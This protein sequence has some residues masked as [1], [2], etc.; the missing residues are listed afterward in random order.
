MR[1]SNLFDA[2]Q[3]NLFLIGFAFYALFCGVVLFL[4]FPFVARLND[5][6]DLLFWNVQSDTADAFFKIIAFL[7]STKVIGIFVLLAAAHAYFSA[8][9]TE[10]FS[11][12]VSLVAA[13][14]VGEILK[15]FFQIERPLGPLV[16]T[17]GF[18]FPSGHAILT[19]VLFFS[20][21]N[22]IGRI[23]RRGTRIFLN[24]AIF[25][26]CLA[27]LISRMYLHAHWFTDIAG[28]FFLGTSI[29]LL[30]NCASQVFKLKS[31]RTW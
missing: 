23:P 18:S 9:K 1:K 27:V 16:D 22:I 15:S 8:R 26:L 5:A 31:T 20:L 29:A 3:K 11:I 14:S 28:G 13:A 4:A 2:R 12:A 10:A 30:F 19:A 17:S 21:T 24:S 7:F 6:I 25:V